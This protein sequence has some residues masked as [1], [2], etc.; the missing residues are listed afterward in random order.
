MIAG[1]IHCSV[2]AGCI[3]CSV[4]VG[5]IHCSVIA[6]C[7]HC[8]VI[9]GC[10]HCP[11]IAGCIHCS[12]I[13]GCIHCSVIAGC[14]HCP[15]IAGCIHC[16]VI[17]GCIHRYVL[18]GCIHCP[19]IAGCIHRYVL[20]GCIYC[21][22]IAGCI[23]VRYS[24]RVWFVRSFYSFFSLV[25]GSVRSS[26]PVSLVRSFV[27][28]VFLP[29]SWF[30]PFVIPC[31]FGSVVRFTRFS[32][33]FVVSIRS[34]VRHSLCLWFGRSFY[35]F[36]SLVRGFCPFYRSS[37][38]ACLVRS[39]YS[40]FSLVRGFCPFYRSSFPVSLVR[41]FVLLVFL[42]C[43]WFLSVLSFVIPCVFGSFVR[44]TRFSPLFVVSV[45]SIV[46]HSLCLWF[47]RSFYSFFSLVRS[48]VRHSLRV[49]FVRFTRFSPLF[50]V[51]VRSIVRH[52]LC[53]WF[54][55]S[56]YSFFSLVRGFCPFYRSLFPACFVRSF[57]LLVFLPC[58]L[59]CPFYRS[60]FPACLVRSFVLLVFLPCS[61][62]C[63][64]VIPCVF[65]SVVR[66]TRFSP[67]F[68]VLSV[69]HSLCLWFGRSFYS[70]FSLVRGFCPFYRSL[71]PA[72]FVRSFYSFFSLVRGF[73]PF[74]RSLFPACLVRSFVLLV[75][76]PCSWFLS[77]VIPC[78]FGSFVRFTRFSPLF[79]VSV[80]SIVRH[81]LC[82]WFVR[83]FYSFFSLVRGSV[84]SIVRYSLRV[85]FV[86]L[87]FLPCSWFL[88]VRSF[89]IP[90]V[91]GSV[92]R[93][94][95]FSP[96][97]VVSVRSIVRHSL[98]LWFGR[99]F[100]SFFSLVRGSVRSI[101]RHS[102]CLW[103]GRSFYSFFSL[104]RGFCPF[105]RS[106]FPVS[107]VRSFVL[108]VFLPCS[109]FLFVRSFVIPCVF[110]SVVR[111][112]RFSPLFVVSVR[113]IVR[114][115]LCLWFVRSFYS[116]FSLV[117]GFCPF[118]RSLFP[119]CL[120]RSFVLLVFLPCSWFLSVLSF[121]IPCVFGSVVRFTRFSPLFV[122]SVR[123][124]VR[125]SL[126]LWFVPSFYSFFSLVRGFCSFDRSSFPVSL[127]RSFVLLV[128]L[129]CSW[130]LSV[131]SFVIPCVFG[132]VVRF[133][134]FSPLF[135]VSVRSIVRHSL[136][137]WFGRSFYSF[138][139][140]VRS[141]VRYS[142][143]VLFVRFTRFSPL[144]VVSV[145]SI[146]RHS[147]CL[148]FVRS[149]YSFFSLVRGFCPFYRSLFPACLVRSFVLLVFL[150]CSW[151][152]FVRSFVIPCV[153]GSVVRFTR[154]SPLFVVSVRSIVRHS[155]C[156]W[157]GRSFYSFFSLV[158]GFCPFYRSSFPVSLVRSF[159]LLV[160]LPCSFYRSLFPA[161]FVRSFYSFFSLVRGFCPFYRSSVPVSLVRS[162][163][164][165]VFL[166][167][168][169]F[170][171]FYRSLFPACLV[172]SFVLLVFLPCSWFLFVR[173]FVIPCVF[174]SV[175]RF[176]RFS[177]LFVVSVRSIVR[178][179]L[180]LWFGRSFYSFFSLV[181][182]S[183]RSIVRH[184][185]CLWF[186]RSF[187]SFF[188]LVRGFCPFYRSSFP[189]SL[190]RSFVLLVF[191]PCSWFLFV[192]SFVIPC[193][194]GSVVRFTRFS[195]LFVVSV[196]SIVRHSLCLWF[197]RS[198]Y[199]FFSLVR[200]S[201]RSIVR[202]SLRV[203]FGRS[204]YSFFSLV[205]GFCS[206]DRSSFPVSLVRSFVLLVFLPCSWFLSVLSFVIPCVFGSVVRFTRFSPLFVVLSVLSFVIPCVFGSVVRFTRF[207]PLFVVSVRS[208]V[209]HSLC[210]W[211]GRSFYSFFSLV[212]GFC[213]FYRSLFPACLVRS[214]VLLVF[215][216][217]SWFLFVRSF[218]IPCVFGSVVRFTRFSPLFVVSVRS[219]V[220][221][222]LRV[223]FVRFTRFSPLFVVSVRSIV[224]HSLCLWFVRSFYSFFSL[225]R[226]FC[227]FYRSSFPV[228][229]VR[230][231]VLLVFLPCS[232]FLS[233]LSFVI[234]CVFG[235]FVRFTR[236]SPLFVVS[237]RSIV[238]HSLCLWFGRSFY[239]FFSLVR[240]FCSFYRSSFP[241]SLVRSFVL[242]V[243]LPC[244]WFLSVL[245]F[246]IP[247]VFGSVVRFT[248]FSPLFVL[249]FVIPCVFCSF[250][251]LVFLPCSWFLSV[252][253][254]VI[255]CVFGSVV[256]FTRFSP[257][258]VVSVRS[259]VR[260]SLRVLF[261]RSFYSFF[262]LVRGSV[263]SIVRYSL[264]V[265]FVRSFYS[266]FS[267]VR[268][269][270][271]SSFPV[272]LVRSFVLLVFLPCSWFLF[273]LSFVIPCVFCSFVLLV[274][275]PCSFYRSSFPA[276]FVRSFYSFFSLV[277]GFCPFYR[278]SF[279]VSLVRSFV[280]LV[281]LPCSWF[282]SV[283]S[284]VIP[285]VFCSVVRFTRFSPL[286]V[287]LSVLSFVIP[288]VFGSF[289]RFTRFSPLFV[290][291]SVRHS[292]CL[293]FGRSFY[294]FFSLVRGS[295]RS[296][297][298]VSLVRSFVLLVFLPCSWFLSVRSFVIPC[299]F[300]SFVLLVFLPCS[301][302]LFIRSFV[303]PCVFGSFVRFTC[304]CPLFVVSVRSIV[305]YS[306][307]FGSFS[308]EAWAA[309]V[310]AWSRS[311]RVWMKTS[312][313]PLTPVR[314]ASSPRSCPRKLKVE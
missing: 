151:F 311:S 164:L 69:R 132:S 31:V 308:W 83:S 219:I 267:L 24:L 148:W 241:V 9:A 275:L 249:S 172:R 265:W 94:T 213:P 45:R 145:R 77:F 248:R 149:F 59:F 173:S 163:V 231:F 49:L 133:T 272:S 196:R 105:Y 167:C 43:S 313:A 122:V 159:V 198:F 126:R 204:F 37:F 140:R 199:S 293:W 299:V 13:A 144:F 305:R 169:W 123:S 142:L 214:F 25:R 91:F 96:L 238:R 251:L 101:V 202:Y 250:V 50:V 237:V 212:R 111:Y 211:F 107:L 224:R 5:C 210:L 40:F 243:F 85:W 309:A 113:S 157:F 168:S 81:S 314:R 76:L 154:F 260:Y 187:Y 292:L 242:L 55:R 153:F 263:R 4:I 42:P 27:L 270:V 130:F 134:R 125:Y 276:C 254:F 82:L 84:R 170:C 271:R 206:F 179:S 201:V 195:P 287:V 209:R 227:P 216:P 261:G 117:R 114:H 72:C 253:S 162:F 178:H 297:F 106:S 100:Y 259:I 288:C 185:L 184:S 137:L 30:C 36:F 65:G 221:H 268:G 307:V 180:C 246:V 143:R 186:G 7:I 26:F 141:I 8:S 29:C 295:V 285:C 303:I 98:C 57:V 58:S 203:W 14:I 89:V 252:L 190:V 194:F 73:C 182:G 127:V 102:L 95:R 218:V 79:V 75:F 78:V 279:P 239:S 277:R 175:V 192:R 205:R 150:P 312:L 53:L 19:V 120:V 64:F 294:S 160:F 306:S 264:R 51:S 301:W 304:F 225:V 244:S 235:S 273:V 71:L 152:L 20:A 135:V 11:V 93:F 289:V 67:L 247:C 228:S 136:C 61:W 46:R 92:V 18:A 208:I 298:P 66:F 171:P 23:H 39:F 266:F 1:C 200:G 255:P 52:S 99:S 258:F 226:G 296:S 291:L 68:V 280:L 183:V 34:I 60:L 278:S 38:P 112:T 56:F 207:S 44:F 87:V 215:L 176:T 128:F 129:P 181:R 17:A 245:S 115:S 197:V 35:S 166:P 230:S 165:L 88:F 193:V 131:L 139:S 74:Y 103:F 138:F 302:F 158:R 222:S 54:G 121:V 6:G 300:C 2:I 80:R 281:F 223:W 269:S 236:F 90:C 108:L 147:L 232:W 97:F 28:L 12:V 48:I 119:A 284:F 290:V 220:R 156:L 3:N 118:Y 21:S 16:S 174:G 286:F 240:G 70:F 274:F 233:V 282:L 283:L 155:L 161:C 86:L 262:S 104:V 188:S 10:I 229:L 41:S 146:V 234:P 109:W 257:L 177:P 116:F 110:G 256:R 15:V 217:C 124:I 191:L 33:L 32:P 47:G 310:A 189:V 63:P 62:F 22:V